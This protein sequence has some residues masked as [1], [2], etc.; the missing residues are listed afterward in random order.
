MRYDGPLSSIRRP[1]TITLE[2]ARRTAIVALAFLGAGL[3][4]A[5]SLAPFVRVGTVEWAVIRLGA[6][7]FS[8]WVSGATPFFAVIGLVGLTAIALLATP[9]ALGVAVGALLGGALLALALLGR[10]IYVQTAFGAEREIL[11]GT[12]LMLGGALATACAG[13]ALIRPGPARTGGALIPATLLAAAFVGGWLLPWAGLAPYAGLEG[14]PPELTSI[15]GWMGRSAVVSA[16]FGLVT[17]I[18]ASR[19][20]AVPRNPLLLGAALLAAGGLAA[21][22]AI[23]VPEPSLLI[24]AAREAF[25][26]ATVAALA[27]AIWSAVRRPT[28]G[29][30]AGMVGAAALVGYALLPLTEVRSDGGWIALRVIDLSMPP[31]IRALHGAILPAALVVVASIGALLHARSGRRRLAGGLLLAAWV[32][33]FSELLATTQLERIRLSYGSWLLGLAVLLL[34]MAGATASVDEPRP[35]AEETATTT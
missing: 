25:L 17:L 27:L 3:M 1:A 14:V 6:P 23:A 30:L 32:V 7:H 10:A 35:A 31:V 34:A 22:R 9:R 24:V 29:A 16:V 18:A 21:A 2:P 19:L 5:G 12:W 33:A 13:I 4:F 20:R 11:L 8:P 26:G 28:L 15:L